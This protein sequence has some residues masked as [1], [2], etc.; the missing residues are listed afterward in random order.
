ME[1][2]EKLSKIERLILINQSRILEHLEPESKNDLQLQ[3]EALEAGYELD[4]FSYVE[5]SIGD[6]LPEAECILVRR[7]LQMCWVLQRQLAKLDE[8]PK[9]L[10]RDAV[11]RVGFDGNYE[12]A[13]MQY[14]EYL[15]EKCGK[16]E[17]IS[18]A[19]DF[20][21]HFPRLPIY[22][23]LLKRYE[24]ELRK[25]YIGDPFTAEAITRILA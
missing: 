24:T 18:T 2:K 13:H 16:F 25:D 5:A 17:D 20:D 22:K 21:S 11:Q 14:A 8:L 6:P 4:Y 9:L 19:S 15:V 7:I 10:H 12:T 23:E 3:R 1:R